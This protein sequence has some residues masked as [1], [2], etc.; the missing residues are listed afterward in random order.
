MGRQDLDGS[1]PN[2]VCGVRRLKDLLSDSNVRRRIRQARGIFLGL[3]FDGTLAPL[4]L[5][6]CDAVLPEG[7]LVLLR[8]L[9]RTSDIRVV[10]ISGRGLADLKKKVPVPEAWFSGSHGLQFHVQGRTTSVRVSG[11]GTLALRRLERTLR[12][13]IGKIP[14]VIFESKGPAF[15][16]HYRMTEGAV[17]K[18]VVSVLEE[19]LADVRAGVGIKGGRGKEVAE[20]LVD[21]VGDKGVALRKLLARWRRKEILPVFIGDD[22]TDETAFREVNRLGGISVL[23]G[24]REGASAARYAL[25]DPQAVARF[26]GDLDAW[27]GRMPDPSKTRRAR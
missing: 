11:K 16:V 1:F 18:Q 24:E 12:A 22:L 19:A 17:R 20:F 2:G 5:R 10:L 4:R 9:A 13:R 15:A 8:R 25:S 21:V 27:R 23:V 26:L 7:V 6:P 3:D 14:G